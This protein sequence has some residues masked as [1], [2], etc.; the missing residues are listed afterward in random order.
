MEKPL[1]PGTFGNLTPEEEGKLQ[2]A[3]VHLF[4]LAGVDNLN[5]AGALDSTPDRTSIFH[6][7]LTDISPDH[8]NRILWSTFIAEHPDVMLLRFLRARKWDVEQ[9]VTMFVSDL[10]WRY[11]VR[12]DDDI[13]RHG[14]SVALRS[15]PSVED[16]AFMMQYRSGKSYVRG[17]DREGRLVYVIRVRLHDPKK[18]S[19]QAMEA[20]TLHNIESI[21]L[22]AQYPQD[23]ACLVFDMTGFGFRNMDFHVVKFLCEVFEARYPESLG[24]V[25]IHNAP[26]IFGGIWKI[27]KPWIDPVI[28]AKIH[29]TSGNADIQR[30]IAKDNLQTRY[31]GQD[32][33]EYQY[34]EPSVGEDNKTK[35]EEKKAKIQDERKE[36]AQEF[37]RETVSWVALDPTSTEAEEVAARRSEISKQLSANFWQLDPYRRARTYYQRAGVIDDKGMVDLQAAGS[38]E[39]A[40]K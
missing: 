24:V 8:F 29:F 30:F 11:V 21:R 19:S 14:E 16:K 25:L 22:L 12:V 35:D 34:I 20:Y 36:L 23:K 6:R 17:M 7:E 13:V 9:A 5:G 31:G 10:D 4:R 3:W 33:W 38:E 18:Q 37:E 15:A 2:E 28:A 40:T 32:E 1:S 39:T 26:Y 27:I